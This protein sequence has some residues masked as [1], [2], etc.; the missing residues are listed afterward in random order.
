MRSDIGVP[1]RH[2]DESRGAC[3]VVSPDATR[4]GTAPPAPGPT[5]PRQGPARSISQ[6][7]PPRGL[8][9]QSAGRDHGSMSGFRI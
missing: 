4:R 5:T 6:S 9:A 2:T 8:G 3:G 7:R 1:H